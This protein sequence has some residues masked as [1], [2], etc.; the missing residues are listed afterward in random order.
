MMLE[1]GMKGIPVI[2]PVKSPKKQGNLLVKNKGFTW[3][4]VLFSH[5]TFV[6]DFFNK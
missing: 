2:L 4:M 1:I 5:R 6:A 3:Y